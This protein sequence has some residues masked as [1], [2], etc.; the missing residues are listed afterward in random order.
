MEEGRYRR[1]STGTPQGGV[2]SPLLANIYLDELDQTWKRKGMSFRERENAHLVR[3]ADDL[4]ILTDKDPQGPFEVLKGTLDSMGLTLHPGKTRLLDA[5]QGNFDF[6]GFNFR[7]VKNPKSGKWFALLRPSHKAQMALKEKVRRLTLPFVQRKIGPL[8]QKE[9]NP[10]VRGWVNYFR[11]G[12][13][14][15]VFNEIREFV[16]CRVRRY[17]RRRQKR[18]GYGWKN[19]P[20]E[21]FYGTL[22]LFYGYRLVGRPAYGGRLR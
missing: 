18:H 1:T 17:L 22:G 16:L 7:K 5:S 9:V 10:V 2:I 21:F 19:L 15:G 20:N 8:I 14:S 6:L 13:S 11:I 3:Y 4:V 12:H